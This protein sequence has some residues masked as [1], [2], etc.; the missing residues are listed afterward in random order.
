MEDLQVLRHT[1]RWPG[2]DP[3]RFAH[4]F[5]QRAQSQQPAD[6]RS[7]DIRGIGRVDDQEFDTGT[8][9]ACCDVLE[10]KTS[11]TIIITVV[12]SAYR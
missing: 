12:W 2:D 11:R 5:H 7:I 10:R 3:E 6:S 1:A 9:D 4:L 8:L